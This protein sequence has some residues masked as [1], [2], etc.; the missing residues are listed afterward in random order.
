MLWLAGLMGMMVLGSI[1]VVSAEDDDSSDQ[2]LAP[3]ESGAEVG[4]DGLLS[5]AA[6]A[7]QSQGGADFFDDPDLDDPDTDDD[8]A[9]PPLFDS[10][11]PIN[12]DMVQTEA[13]LI[14]GD[15]GDDDLQ[16]TAFTDLMNGGDGDDTMDGAGNDDDMLGGAGN[17]MMTGGEG[18][19]S[20]HGE[21]G[22]DSLFGNAGDDA[23]FGHDGDDALYGD[24]GDDVLQGGLGDDAMHGGDGNDGLHGREGADTLIG[25]RG[26]DALFGGDDGDLLSGLADRGAEEDDAERDYLNGNDGADTLIGGAGDVLTGGADA[27]HFVLVDWAETDG[28]NA[29]E[30]A[31]FDAAED[32]LVVVF[33]D[34][35]GAGAPEIDIQ[36]SPTDPDLIEI[37]SDGVVLASVHVDEAPQIGN[38]ALVGASVASA[39]FGTG[40]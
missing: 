7:A 37:R 30:L 11:S 19:D 5:D 22:A 18:N 20:M 2:D 8:D 40:P 36:L 13:S 17:D 27:D 10:I 3:E 14:D 32:Q 33:D 6:M 38:I 15:D 1:A 23:L 16:G 24:K 9:L 29:A 35:D 28:T 39:L 4:V 34:S 12:A 31:D 26:E 21:A 25:G